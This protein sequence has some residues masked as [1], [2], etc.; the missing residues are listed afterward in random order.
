MWVD[1]T[2]LVVFLC[3]SRA[4][5]DTCLAELDLPDDE[6]VG[7]QGWLVDEVLRLHFYLELPVLL[8]DILEGDVD[9][10]VE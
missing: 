8:D 6:F 2:V 3:D 7:V 10:A 4:L 5:I 9:E 1:G